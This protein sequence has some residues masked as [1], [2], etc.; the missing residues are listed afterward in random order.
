MRCGQDLDGRPVSAAG[1][2][3][4]KRKKVFECHKCLHVRYCSDEC[5]IEAAMGRAKEAAGERNVLVHGATTAQLAPCDELVVR[6][7]DEAS[8]E[9]AFVVRWFVERKHTART[10]CRIDIEQ[11]L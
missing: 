7:D 8:S 4:K 1:S 3:D 10:D 11:K 5:M 6:R 2:A 9:K